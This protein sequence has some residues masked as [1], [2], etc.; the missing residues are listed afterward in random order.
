[1]VYGI[2]AI[3]ELSSHISELFLWLVYQ[4]ME[5]QLSFVIMAD[6]RAFN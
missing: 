1:M 4:T 3:V 6:Y 2:T 5:S